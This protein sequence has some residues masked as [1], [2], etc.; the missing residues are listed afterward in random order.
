MLQWLIFGLSF[1][2]PLIFQMPLACPIALVASN[3]LAP[4]PPRHSG[5]PRFLFALG[6]QTLLQ[7]TLRS[8]TTTTT[9]TIM[10]VEGPD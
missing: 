7:D 8:I 2:L 1:F 6:L 9:I 10:Y 5:K 4:D 3:S